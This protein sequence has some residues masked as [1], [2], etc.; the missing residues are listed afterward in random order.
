MFLW[1]G[2]P[3]LVVGGRGFRSVGAAAPKVGRPAIALSVLV[4]LVTYA[5]GEAGQT[6]QTRKKF[7]KGTLQ[8]IHAFVGNRPVI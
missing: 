1:L 8:K 4:L 2:P 5:L 7:E 6:L 3:G